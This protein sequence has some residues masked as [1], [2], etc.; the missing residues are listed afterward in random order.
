MSMLPAD[1]PEAGPRALTAA[2]TAVVSFV[3]SVDQSYSLKKPQMK[4]EV[5]GKAWPARN[6]Q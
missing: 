5:G 4:V 1:G 3:L 2:R 6:A